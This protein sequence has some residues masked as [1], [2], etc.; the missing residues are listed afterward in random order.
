MAGA[1][2]RSH[3]PDGRCVG[4]FGPTSQGT[5]LVVDAELTDR[6]VPQAL[7]KRFGERNFW[8]R[9]TRAECAAK[10]ADTPIVVWL[11]MH[12]LDVAPDAGVVTVAP[13]HL[14]ANLVVT[15]AVGL[16]SMEEQPATEGDSARC[17]GDHRSGTSDRR[18]TEVCRVLLAG[19]PPT[20]HEQKVR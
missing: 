3:L 14:A 17:G 2:A 16:D 6:P 7:A 18:E 5:V 11:R 1:S 4:W 13:D 9:W 19:S 10:L 12:G 20:P 8:V 15:V